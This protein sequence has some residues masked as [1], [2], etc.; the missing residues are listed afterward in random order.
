MYNQIFNQIE[1][2]FDWHS[3]PA[4][5]F[6]APAKMEELDFW[7]EIDLDDDDD[8][9]AMIRLALRAL[10]FSMDREAE[11]NAD[12][13]KYLMEHGFDINAQVPGGD[14]LLLGAVNQNLSP[15]ILRKLIELGADPYMTDPDGDNMLV[16]AAQQKYDRRE[17]PERGALGL[18]IAEHLDLSRLDG[19]DRFGITPLMYAA[20]FDHVLLAKALIE[21]GSDVN[22]AGTQP[23]GSNSYWI[24]LDGVT[25]LALACRSGS[26]EIAR[27]LL[28]AGADETARS[29]KGEPPCFSLLRY[30]HGFHQ[31]GRYNDPIYGR[32]CEILAMLREP[33]LTDEQGYSLLMRALEDSRDPFDK[34]SAY[35]DN[36]PIA[37]ALIERG[38]DLEQAGNDGRRALHLAVRCVGD[39][40]KKLVK[41]GA[42][43]NAQ[44]AR[45]DTPLLIACRWCDEKTVRYLLK[46][47]ADPA[48]QNNEGKTAMDLC[49]ARGFNSAI[50]LMMAQ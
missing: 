46:A 17:E 44:D 24:K 32:K 35:S 1:W 50:E 39:A 9:A 18:Y 4:N 6:G 42:E 40:W 8:L 36:L 26:V 41:A 31:R 27:M 47:G 16:R 37:L 2:C 21:H 45:G 29:V 12:F 22:A 11:P 30:P 15:L 3:D 43:L 34:A 49:A 7:D 13:I 14:S 25:P 48:L 5:C 20:L 33:A 23:V 38:V 28:E 19:P 10:R